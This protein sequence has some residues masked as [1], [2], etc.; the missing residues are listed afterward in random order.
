MNPQ[1]NPDQK[2]KVLKRK[3]QPTDPVDTW[4]D[5]FQNANPEAPRCHQFRNKTP[6]KKERMA[7]AA[8]YA[9]VNPSK[10]N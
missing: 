2:P 4:I 9:A 3:L 5:Q 10:K 7:I 8:H 6:E 1:D